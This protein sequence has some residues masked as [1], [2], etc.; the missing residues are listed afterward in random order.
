MPRVMQ[1]SLDAAV[2]APKPFRKALT[3]YNRG[4]LAK[5]EAYCLAAL[6]DKPDFFDALHLL[7]I[8]QS[9]TGRHDGALDY[10]ARAL[11]LDPNNPDLI[12]NRGSALTEAARYEEA[13]ACYDRSLEIRPNYANAHNNR[14]CV[15]MEMQRYEDALTSYSKALVLDSDNAEFINNMGRALTNLRRYSDALDCYGDALAVRPD[16]IE[17]LINRGVTLTELKQFAD[18]L[19]CFDAALARAPDHIDALLNRGN[20]LYRLDRFEEAVHDYDRLLARSPRRPEVYLN[21]GLALTKLQRFEAAFK[22]YDEAFRH[23]GDAAQIEIHR[24]MTLMETGEAAKALEAI[25]Q[26]IEAR[27][28]YPEGHNTRGMFFMQ[29][30]RL[31]EA[32][33]NWQRALELRSDYPEAAWH[34]GYALLLFGDF[35]EGWRHYESRRIQKGTAWIKLNGPE[36]RGEP[37]QGKRLLLY[38]EQGL[39]DALQF[40]RFVRVATRM[41]AQVVLGVHGPLTELFRLVDETLII[42]RHGESAPDFDYHAPIMSMPFILGLGEKIPADVPYLRADEMRVASWKARLPQS[43]FRVGIAWQGSKA[44]PDRWVP[45]GAFAPLSRIPGVTLISLQKT[46]GL[47]QLADLP[48]GMRVETLG[49]E[50]DAGP[51]AFLDS[52]AVMTSLDLIVSIDT[53]I[54]HLAGALGR[55]V[56]IALKRHPDWRWMLDRGDSPWYPTARLFRQKQKGDWAQVMEEIAAELAALVGQSDKASEPTQ[57]QTPL[58][59]VSAPIS[60]GELIDK[61]VILEIKAARMTDPAKLSEVSKELSLLKQIDYGAAEH[62]QEI[63]AVQE[64]LRRVNEKLWDIEDRLRECERGSKFGGEFV[65]LARAVYI[66]NDQRATLKRRINEISGSALKEIKAHPAY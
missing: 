16:Y 21:R 62:R 66:T 27:P 19:V 60:I 49:P 31:P 58:G 6:R 9:R 52:A 38:M 65:E 57:G 41:G 14:G 2:L 8:V 61:I 3:A 37:L 22:S 17:A 63:K 25:D 40:V 53:A 42:Y 26:L 32:I 36:W 56:W 1:N 28:N 48:A 43:R 35:V 64:E 47:D 10:F 45:L 29:L 44:D 18:A 20:A 39:G 12:N 5:T 54:A 7:G 15:L 23:N 11:Q 50:F 4:D 24:A 13:L 33:A 55:P 51:D 34:L 30:G 59:L 46:D